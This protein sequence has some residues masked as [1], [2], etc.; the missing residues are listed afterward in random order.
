LGTY[1][2]IN[3]EDI[4]SGKYI[5]WDPSAQKRQGCCSSMSPGPSSK[6]TEEVFPA[7]ACT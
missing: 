1:V 7:V 2:Y 6:E 3:N 5:M 4:S